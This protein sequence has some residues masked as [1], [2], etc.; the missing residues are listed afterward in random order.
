MWLTE[1][2]Q[3]GSTFTLRGRAKG[4]FES[5]GKFKE[6]LIKSDYVSNASVESADVIKSEDATQDIRAFT[7]KVEL[8]SIE[9]ET[10]E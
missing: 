10:G 2:K 3:E 8:N 6:A 5:I 1:L 9:G 7:I 4:T